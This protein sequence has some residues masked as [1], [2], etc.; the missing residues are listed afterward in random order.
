MYHHGQKKEETQSCKE[1][2]VSLQ[3]LQWKNVQLLEKADNFSS[4]LCCGNEYWKT[5]KVYQNFHSIFVS[6]HQYFS[7]A[8]CHPETLSLHVVATFIHLGGGRPDS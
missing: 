5:S 3:E 8:E 4:R 2:K 1:Q 6:F 7:G